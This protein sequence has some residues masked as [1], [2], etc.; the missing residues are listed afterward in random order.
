MIN[1]DALLIVKHT[2]YGKHHALKGKCT[3]NGHSLWSDSLKRQAKN[4]K[5][6][7]GDEKSPHTYMNQTS[8][9]SIKKDDKDTSPL[10]LGAENNT[11]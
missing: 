6:V 5:R 8:T 2:V 4:C 7:S 10:A 9:R 3:S 11:Q 1:A